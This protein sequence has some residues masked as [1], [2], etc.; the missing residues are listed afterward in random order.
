MRVFVTGASG[1]I[2]R[3]V[4]QAL[5]ARGDSV[6]AVSRSG[7]AGAG[8]D[9]VTGDPTQAGPWRE[10]LA[11]CDAVLHL[12]GESVGGRRW[13]AAQKERIRQ[14]RVAS[15]EQLT[16]AI[17][18]LSAEQRPGVLVTASGVDYYGFDRSDTPVG[19]DALSGNTFLAEVCREWEAATAHAAARTA[20]LRIGLVLG[21]G[22]SPLAKILTPFRFFLGGPV[23]SGEQ[24]TSWVHV[25]D[26]VGAA[27]FALDEG[28]P[29]GPINVVAASVR[30][31]DFAA[32][33]GD[34]LKRP[35]WLQVPSVAVRLVAGELAEYLVHGRRVVPAALERAGYHFRRPELP[36]ALAASI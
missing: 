35:S 34:A 8:V 28:G 17:A 27:L 20:A 21:K 30:Q 11:G 15:G 33:L 6:V 32:A 1:F 25:D 22:D 7:S 26:V 24:W 13:N 12:A 36:G 14:S 19:E 16:R 23:G 2:G 3:A 29:S 10:R 18:A 4:S 9:V 31:R 5:I